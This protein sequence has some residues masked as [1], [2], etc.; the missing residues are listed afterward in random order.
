MTAL[1]PEGL[2]VGDPGLETLEGF[3]AEPDTP[4]PARAS[5]PKAATAVGNALA[6]LGRTAPPAAGGAARVSP[7]VSPTQATRTALARLIDLGDIETLNAARL[8]MKRLC[9]DLFDWSCPPGQTKATKAVVKAVAAALLATDATGRSLYAQAVEMLGFAAA[10]APLL[11]PDRLARLISVAGNV[12]TAFAPERY[13]ITLA[14]QLRAIMSHYPDKHGSNQGARREQLLV[15]LWEEAHQGRWWDM[16]SGVVVVRTGTRHRGGAPVGAEAEEV[17]RARVQAA[18]EAV[19]E[20]LAGVTRGTPAAH[21]AITEQ[22]MD[23]ALAYS[24][25]VG[26]LVAELPPSEELRGFFS[27]VAAK[28]RSGEAIDPD[29]A[30][31]A[32]S[33]WWLKPAERPESPITFLARTLVAALN[34]EEEGVEPHKLP[35]KPKSFREL[36]PQA[37]VTGFPYPEAVRNLHQTRLPGVNRP[38]LV[39][40]IANAAEL[41]ANR[42]FM[43]NCTYSYK[44][45][46]Q[47]GAVVILK[48]W[49]GGECYNAAMRHT[50]RAWA[51]QEI[52]SRFNRGG[53]PADVRAG[54]DRL[55]ANLPAPGPLVELPQEGARRR[56]AV[57]YSG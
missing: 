28:L 36:Y 45:S 20:L 10:A 51:Y 9:R 18:Q 52:N 55:I 41:A 49:D 16:T 37:S 27:D 14:A 38:V 39:E 42:D 40:L 1:I 4:A 22:L 47:R 35:E 54:F 2:P 8:D 56:K 24:P 48:L 17:D 3:E 19:R 33:L 23:G 25:Q 29:L 11:E 50:E 53:V 30:V 46:C 32:S 13:T 6:L 34:P 43:G 21:A 57:A 44:D 15:S 26:E 7:V 31:F 5:K 12:S